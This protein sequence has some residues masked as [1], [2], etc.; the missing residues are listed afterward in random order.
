MEDFTM[1]KYIRR[2]RQHDRMS[3]RETAY[4]GIFLLAGPM[5]LAIGCQTAQASQADGTWRVRNL[6][7]RIFDC[8]QQ[9]CGR[10][11][12][13]KEVAKRPSQCRQTIIWGLAP[14]AQNE[15]AGG[16]ILD[17]NNGKTYQL[18]ASYRQDGTLR[19]RIFKG[20]PLLGKT[21]ILTRVELRNFEGRC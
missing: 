1:L 3:F 6:V 5:L 9:V 12:W 21:E 8:Q 2:F 17:P 10:I 14:T 16:A 19:A 18:S 11:V 13:I 20:I 15:W 7:V 4:I